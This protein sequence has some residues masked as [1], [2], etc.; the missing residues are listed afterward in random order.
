MNAYQSIVLGLIQG[1]TEFL[2]VSSSGHLL[3]GSI[4]LNLPAPGLSLSVLF[5]LGTALA[6]CVMLWK[7]IS[8]LISSVLAP[9]RDGQ[10]ARALA[11]VGFVAAAS[12]PGA[13][14]GIAFGDFLDA[15]FG[16]GPV[17]AAG[18][19]ITGFI[20]WFGARRTAE[21]PANGS[22]PVRVSRDVPLEP[23]ST[24]SLGRALIVGVCQA[25]A[26]IPGISRSGTTITSGLI[27]GMSREDAARFSFLLALPAVLGGALL[28]YR[29]ASLLGEVGVSGMGLLGA[30][31]ALF[32]GMFALSAVFRVVRK[33]ELSRFAYYCWAVGAI[34]LAWLILK[35]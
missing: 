16:S 30:A 28:D 3:L 23:L 7:E 29:D 14:V 25:V 27:T 17:A 24:V 35:R 12:I 20:L 10:R 34:S 8:Y 26:I 19:I 9:R 32:S 6:T 31:V 13:V 1:L 15:V 4:A 21:A 11:I 33:G 18:L 22:H 2:P 5:H